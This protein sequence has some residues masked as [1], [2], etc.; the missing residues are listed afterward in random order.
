ML[1]LLGRIVSFFSQSLDRF[2]QILNYIIIASLV[3]SKPFSCLQKANL[4]VIDHS[5]I[6]M[7]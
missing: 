2:N 7:F 6:F 5:E 4:V 1:S 3:P